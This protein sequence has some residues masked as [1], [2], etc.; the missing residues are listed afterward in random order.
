MVWAVAGVFR[1]AFGV[2]AAST[3]EL[4]VAVVAE[5]GEV[6]ERVPSA[7]FARRDVVRDESAAAGAEHALVVVAGE[8]RVA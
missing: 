7:V 2:A 6:L 1:E 8:A 3:F 5:G 4:V